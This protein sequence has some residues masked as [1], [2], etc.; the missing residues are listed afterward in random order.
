MKKHPILTLILT[1]RAVVFLTASCSD[2]ADC[3]AGEGVLRIALE[4]VS[5]GVQSRSVPSQ[6]KVPEAKDFTISVANSRGVE[7]YREPYS[8]ARIPLAAGE[9]TVTASFGDNPLI[10]I[11]APF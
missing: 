11:D 3:A 7:V 8:E 9:Y 5:P 10:G 2:E 4:N 6:L 1:L